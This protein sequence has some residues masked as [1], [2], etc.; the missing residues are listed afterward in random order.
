M[1]KETS[2][3][4]EVFRYASVKLQWLSELL[5]VRCCVAAE[6]YERR[7]KHRRATGAT[8]RKR[9]QGK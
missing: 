6:L 4:I 7:R 3:V 1:D 8:C 2:G 9:D 5:V